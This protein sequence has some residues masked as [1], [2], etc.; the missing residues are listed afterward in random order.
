MVQGLVVYEL[1]F[2]MHSTSSPS[3]CTASALFI[4]VSASA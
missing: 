3:S 2:V 4:T 1:A